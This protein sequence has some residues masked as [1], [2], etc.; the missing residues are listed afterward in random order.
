M[1]TLARA[2][3]PKKAASTH[4]RADVAITGIDTRRLER[5]NT[6]LFFMGDCFQLWRSLEPFQ[7]IVQDGGH[8]YAGESGPAVQDQ[9]VLQH[10]G[11]QC[12]YVVRRHEIPALHGGPDLC[13]PVEPPGGPGA[14]PHLQLGMA[15]GGGGQRHDV[16]GHRVGQVYLADLPLG[17][18]QLLGIGDRPHLV[19][20]DLVPKLRSIRRSSFGVG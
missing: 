1:R 4:S 8:R 16:I 18:H 19:K 14:C 12:L 17:L 20:G 7:H 2:L 11:G 15:S 9:A 10:W 5:L 13:R 6:S 3:C